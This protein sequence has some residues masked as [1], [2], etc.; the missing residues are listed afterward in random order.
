MM[1]LQHVT[2][3]VQFDFRTEPILTLAVAFAI[4]DPGFLIPALEKSS[5]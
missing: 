2:Y 5:G 1:E 3:E 4:P